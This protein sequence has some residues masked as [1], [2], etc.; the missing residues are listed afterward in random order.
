MDITRPVY[1]EINLNDFEFNIKQIQNYVGKNIELMPVIKANGYGT[2]I[3]RKLEILNKFNIVAV[4][5]VDEG[6]Y[7][8]NLG[9]EKEIFVLN[10]PFE[11]EIGKII[12]YNIVIGISSYDFANK[13]AE[14]GRDISV[15]V[16]IGTGMGRTGVHPYKIEKYLKSLSPNIKI[17]GIYTHFSSADIDDEYSKKQLES[18]KIA[19]E[20][21]KELL[22][23]IKYIH[24]AA[25]NALLN[26]PESH[27]NLVRPGIILYGYPASD[28]TFEKIN[29]KPIA[30]LKAQITFL[31]TVEKGT[32]IGYG[33]SYITKKQTEVATVPIG[34][35]DGFRRDFSNGW[36][37]LINGKKAPIIGKVCMDSFMVDVSDIE[38]VAIGD[39][40][41]I[42][43][44]ENITLEQLATKCNTINYEILCTI[45]TRVPRKFIR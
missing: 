19:V 35:A 22:G 15:H 18:F 12:R 13:L 17:E 24:A 7:L 34:Y 21:A 37:V 3:N 11:S 8:R 16:E 44:N 1:L 29:L 45:G 42:W 43:D 30:K 2:Y 31:K 14:T 6:V 38:D 20:K 23:E 33:R 41:I 25:S 40:V 10:Q 32:S 26:Y 39:E 27:F 28:E 9:Y 4:A 36:E 5:T